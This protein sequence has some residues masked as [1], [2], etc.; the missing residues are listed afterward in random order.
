[1]NEDG[2][3]LGNQLL[4]TGV[5]GIGIMLAIALTFWPIT[6]LVGF[7]WLLGKRQKAKGG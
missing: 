3:G 5:L 4:T 7:V 2:Y 1:M 6:L